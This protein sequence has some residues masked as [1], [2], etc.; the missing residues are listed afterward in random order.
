MKT[1]HGIN[2]AYAIPEELQASQLKFTET[3]KMKVSGWRD[4]RKGS[5]RIEDDGRLDSSRL[6]TERSTVAEAKSLH[7]NYLLLRTAEARRQI[8]MS[9]GV[10]HELEE[11]IK[12]LEEK[13][14]AIEVPQVASKQD[15]SSDDI[16]NIR[17]ERR[18]KAQA[19]AELAAAKSELAGIVEAKEEAEKFIRQAEAETILAVCRTEARAHKRMGVYINSASRKAGADFAIM[20]PE[21]EIFS[22]VSQ[23]LYEAVTL[24]TIRGRF[25]ATGAIAE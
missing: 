13:L 15:L 8:P 5:L 9:L 18:R 12:E 3:L 10:I 7:F 16:I 20:K 21:D 6:Q 2:D 11:R 19:V 24:G 25:K 14:A 17:A 23:E 4:V 22:K 1:K